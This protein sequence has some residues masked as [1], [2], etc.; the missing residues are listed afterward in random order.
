MKYES[1]EY[2]LR[3]KFANRHMHIFH[4]LTPSLLYSFPISQD[5]RKKS[6]KQEVKKIGYGRRE[7][8]ASFKCDK[9]N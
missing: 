5:R 2:E 9:S 1:Y 6:N 8:R 3:I 4:C 7:E